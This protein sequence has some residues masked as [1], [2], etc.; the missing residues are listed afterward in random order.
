MDK[1]LIKEDISN[2]KYLIGYKP[3]RVI[4]EQVEPEM[5]EAGYED[6]K[7]R[8]NKKKEI[9][10]KVYKGTENLSII[11]GSLIKLFKLDLKRLSPG[12]ISLDRDLLRKSHFLTIELG[13]LYDLIDSHKRR[14]IN[15]PLTSK[16]LEFYD[17]DVNDIMEKASELSSIIEDLKEN[18]DY[19]GD[20][21]KWLSHTERF[22]D[23]LAETL[24]PFVK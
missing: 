3:G 11:V 8:A 12:E 7:Q 13:K 17:I 1:K 15:N 6:L 24:F 16:D 10:T 21:G 22:L 18:T 23:K 14:D 2:M 4:S 9:S 5:N 20:D 19:F